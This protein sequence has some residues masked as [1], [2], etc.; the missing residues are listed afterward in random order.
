MDE[1]GKAFAHL[2]TRALSD[3]SL[4]DYFS[5]LLLLLQVGHWKAPRFW[6]VHSNLPGVWF[7]DIISGPQETGSLSDAS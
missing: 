7:A 1:T 6:I 3:Q 2:L 5:A 4:H